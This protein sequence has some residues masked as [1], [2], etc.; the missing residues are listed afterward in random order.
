MV[1]NPMDYVEQMGKAGASGFT[2]HVEVAKGKLL[3]FIT[4]HKM[5]LNDIWLLL[6]SENWQELVRK[7]KSAGMRPGVALKPGTPVEEVYPLVNESFAWVVWSNRVMSSLTRTMWP[8][9]RGKSGGNGSSDDSGAWIWRPEVHAQ[10]DGQGWFNVSNTIC[11]LKFPCNLGFNDIYI[12]G[13][14]SGHWGRSIQ[15][16][17]L[18]WMEG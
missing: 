13:D 2:F 11:L 5:Y 9:W 8:G 17:I 16:L 6:F 7:V 1:T 3:I 10:H 18:R 12:L 4:L 14:R 15:H